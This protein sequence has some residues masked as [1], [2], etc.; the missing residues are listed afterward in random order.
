MGTVIKESNNTYTV[1]YSYYDKQGKRHQPKERGFKKKRDAD[2]R[3]IEVESEIRNKTFVPPSDMLFTEYVEQWLERSY[4][5]KVEAGVK[6][7]KTYLYYKAL[8]S[9]RFEEYFKG[10]LWKDINAD[11]IE[12]YLYHLSQAKKNDGS[13][14]SKNTIA[15]YYQGLRTL[16]NYAK[17]RKDISESP[18]ANID[19]LTIKRKKIEFWEPEII[20]QALKLFEDTDIYF[21]VQMSILTSMRLGEICGID[22]RLIDFDNMTYDVSE[23]AQHVKGKGVQ[24]IP[25][26]TEGASS[27]IP[28]NAEAAEILKRRIKKIK[29]NKLQYGNAYDRTYDGKLSVRDDGTLISPNL[30]TR[31]FTKILRKQ[32]KIKRITFHGLRH[33]SAVFL[34][35]EGAERITLQML[36]RHSEAKSTEVYADAT[37]NMM[38]DAVDKI[39]LDKVD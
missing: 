34:L 39:S 13:E 26:K 29:E 24:F 23:Q 27:K 15:K 10:V 30:V 14:L 20:P 25:P 31:K 32:D 22:E 36:L 19:P 2:D 21:H 5:R 6:K 33:S 1:R 17:K 37:N 28:I 3:L 35:S 8:F 16:F 7:P 38:R 12:D 11:V 9:D 18:V 4:Q